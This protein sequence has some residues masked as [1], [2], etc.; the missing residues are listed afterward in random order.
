MPTLESRIPVFLMDEYF[1]GGMSSV[2]FQEVREFRSMAYSTGSTQLGR[3][4]LL[5]PNSPIA[6]INYVATQGDKAMSA[7]TLVDSLLH[8]M[9][10]IEKNFQV[11]RQNTINNINNDYPSFRKMGDFIAASRRLGF[12]TEPRKGQAELLRASTMDDLKKFFDENLKNNAGHRVLGIIGNKKKLN[13][14]ELEKYGKVIF[15]K[16]KDLFRK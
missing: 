6:F 3:P 11:A 10:L 5:H 1:G 4:R 8:D 7:I 14:K 15:L 9:P 13:L 16:E 12:K 2:L